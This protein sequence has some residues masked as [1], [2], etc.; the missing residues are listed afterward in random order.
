MAYG[1]WHFVN[2]IFNMG[3]L[4]DCMLMGNAS[5]ERETLLVGDGEEIA[6]AMALTT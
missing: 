2:F 6:G 5:V 1:R 4:K 3:V